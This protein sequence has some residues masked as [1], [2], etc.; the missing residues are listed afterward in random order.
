MPRRTSSAATQSQLNL[1]LDLLPKYTRCPDQSTC[2]I[3]KRNF[4]APKLHAIAYL[5]KELRNN[6]RG[7]LLAGSLHVDSVDEKNIFEIDDPKA[8]KLL[9]SDSINGANSTFVTQVWHTGVSREILLCFLL[10]QALLHILGL[11]HN[12][13]NESRTYAAELKTGTNCKIPQRSCVEIMSQIFRGMFLLVV[14]PST[15]IVQLL[16]N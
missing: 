7:V 12:P 9:Y 8:R 4:V 14:C 10:F 16:I 1:L 5:V 13:P 15:K 2:R 6:R 11:T 3:V